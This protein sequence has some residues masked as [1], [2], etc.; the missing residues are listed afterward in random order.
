MNFKD[1]VGTFRVISSFTIRRKKEFYLIGELLEGS[2]NENNYIN[3]ILNSS[4]AISAK[5]SS[6]ENVDVANDSKTYQLIIIESLDDEMN[7]I[8]FHQNVE[9]ENVYITLSGE[10]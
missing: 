8:L 1:K 9:S 2:L 4:L 7:D 10:E 6:L 5:I 3:I